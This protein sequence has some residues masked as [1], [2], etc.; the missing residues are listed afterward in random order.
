[1]YARYACM[2]DCADAIADAW[3]DNT[4]CA[5]ADCLHVNVLKC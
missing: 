4:G 1:M 2:A 3:G 5:H